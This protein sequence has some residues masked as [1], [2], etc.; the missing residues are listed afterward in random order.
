MYG[1]ADFDTSAHSMTDELRYEKLPAIA[2]VSGARRAQCILPS[3]FTKIAGK[4]PE[5]K[6][7][8][9]AAETL[10]YQSGWFT[11]CNA[12]KDYSENREDR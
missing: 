6:A 2:A 4:I 3:I 10:S 5:R 11:F 7:R 12:W 1:L 8:A 9:H